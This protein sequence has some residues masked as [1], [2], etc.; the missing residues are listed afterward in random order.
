MIILL[1]ENFPLR[2]YTKLQNESFSVEHILLS[3][4]GISDRLIFARLQREELVFLTQDKDFLKT[5]SDCQSKHHLVPRVPVD[6]DRSTSGNLAERRE[7]IL[8]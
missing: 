8:F 3:H 7:A 5:A 4:R 6:G 2:L 1:D